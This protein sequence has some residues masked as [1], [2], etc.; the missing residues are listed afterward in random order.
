VNGS[1]APVQRACISRQV[2][3]LFRQSHG[4]T[5]EDEGSEPGPL[6]PHIL[7]TSFST[8]EQIAVFDFVASSDY[9]LGA[10]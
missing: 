4:K 3:A 8:R 9:F 6:T 7:K 1:Y 2:L 10:T 5:L